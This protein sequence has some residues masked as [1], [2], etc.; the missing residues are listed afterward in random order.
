M[1]ELDLK[2]EHELSR[3]LGRGRGRKG[4]GGGGRKGEEGGQGRR[5]PGLRQETSG[6]VV[7][8]GARDGALDG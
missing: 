1:L 7:V 8:L 3:P 5:E 6:T 2:D 4:G